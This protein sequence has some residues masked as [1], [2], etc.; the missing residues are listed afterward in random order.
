VRHRLAGVL[1]ELS[2]A[3][4]TYGSLATE[5]DAPSHELLESEL[6]RHLAAANATTEGVVR[7]PSAFGMTVVW[8]PCV[9]AITE[10]VV[11]RSMPTA[12][13]ITASC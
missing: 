13:A 6:E 3:V 2:A 9:A 12:T 8:P 7:D 1:R 11:P 4:R 5:F 10:L